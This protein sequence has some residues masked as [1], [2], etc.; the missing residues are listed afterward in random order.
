MVK[1]RFGD[2]AA[3]QKT[4]LVLCSWK[5][6]F[7]P[8]GYFLRGVCMKLLRP[9]MGLCAGLLLCAVI[10]CSSSGAASGPVG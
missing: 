3:S 4:A 10:A 7:V 9:G 1:T 6:A 2:Q 8:A 5:A